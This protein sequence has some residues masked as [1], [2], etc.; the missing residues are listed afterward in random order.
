[1]HTAAGAIE[2]FHCKVT[3]TR[4]LKSLEKDTRLG[5]FFSFFFFLSTMNLL[6]PETVPQFLKSVGI[7]DI[8]A[9]SADERIPSLCG[10]FC[11]CTRL[12][13]VKT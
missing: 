12:D 9:A 11:H 13:K 3:V 6:F 8:L 5:V 10:H 1:M 7:M 2:W 4:N